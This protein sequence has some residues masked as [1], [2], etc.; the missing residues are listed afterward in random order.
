VCGKGIA[1]LDLL[2]EEA[3]T[4]ESL[5]ALAERIAPALK[6]SNDLVAFDEH[7]PIFIFLQEVL[8]LLVEGL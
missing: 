8:F 6:V 4:P 7:I 5:V 3:L 2:D 1:L